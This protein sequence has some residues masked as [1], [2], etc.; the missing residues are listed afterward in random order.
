M[1]LRSLKTLGVRMKAHDFNARKIA[2]FLEEHPKVESI[3]YPGL[4][5]HPQHGLAQKQMC[6]FGG[7]ISFYIKG[8]LKEAKAF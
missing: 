2:H 8:G 3:I 1:C 5:S 6:G 4:K 7:M